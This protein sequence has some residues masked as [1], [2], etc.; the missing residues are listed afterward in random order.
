MTAEI[1]TR[2]S[3]LLRQGDADTAIEL[4][5]RTS[6]L[7]GRPEAF[8]A[9][10]HALMFVGHYEQALQPASR[11]V[12]AAPDEPAYRFLRARVCYAAQEF[13]QVVEDCDA[14]L[15]GESRTHSYY[16]NS[17]GVLAAAACWRL[18]QKDQARQYLANVDDGAVVRVAGEVLDAK[19]LQSKLREGRRWTP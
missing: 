7:S 10:A 17:L 19:E 3:R 15:E 9:W 8:S 5:R 6:T 16:A 13:P 2:V 12:D 1:T 4:A 18:G 11:A 14:G